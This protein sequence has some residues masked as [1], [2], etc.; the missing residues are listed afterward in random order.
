MLDSTLLES[1][2]TPGQVA[3]KDGVPSLTAPKILDEV[4]VDEVVLT[5]VKDR[6]DEKFL[7]S[8][9]DANI[10][11]NSLSVAEA[12]PSQ[13]FLNDDE[14]MI[15]F[16]GDMDQESDTDDDSDEKDGST[17]L[18]EDSDPTAQKRNLLARL[19]VVEAM[20]QQV[21]KEE[22]LRT[23]R[24]ASFTK[25][26]TNNRVI[27]TSP[28]LAENGVDHKR[29]RR[30]NPK[31]FDAEIDAEFQISGSSLLARASFGEGG[32]GVVNIPDSQP[33][34]NGENTTTAA[35]T[36]ISPPDYLNRIRPP[37]I[38][39]AR[40]ALAQKHRVF[41]LSE[42]STVAV[43]TDSNLDNLSIRELHEA[44]RKAFGRDTS[45][46]DKHWLKRQI[47][48]GLSKQNA[49][50]N[51]KENNRSKSTL[52]DSN[53]KSRAEK[54]SSAEAPL[55][56]F[57]TVG[58]NGKRKSKGTE[59]IFSPHECKKAHRKTLSLSGLSPLNSPN[60]GITGD[61][62]GGTNQEGTLSVVQ[63]SGSLVGEKRIRKPNRRYI[64]DEGDESLGLA[65]NGSRNKSLRASTRSTSSIR[66]TS[67]NGRRSKHGNNGI[68]K[69][70]IDSRAAKLVKIAHS[71]RAARLDIQKT[72][73]KVKFRLPA[74]P[75]QE[76]GEVLNGGDGEQV[77][78]LLP[79]RIDE[80]IGD[81][82]LL[83]SQYQT[84]S[85]SNDEQAV[86]TVPTANGGTRRKHH[87][88]WTLREVLTLVEG[89]ARCGGGKWADIKKLAFSTVSYR[90][91]VDLKD[92][93]RNLLRAS[94]AQL[95]PPK[96]GETR[97]KQ[98]SAA[99][100]SQLLAR[101]RELAALNNQAVSNV[102]AGSS[103]SRSGRVV[104]R[105]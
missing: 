59:A 9:E 15:H 51:G 73:R 86:V 35:V 93:W 96:Q 57:S 22:Q 64:E 95:H 74:A 103:T 3:G 49:T 52:T 100:P 102:S 104:H 16:D 56:T 18:L 58:V 27:S 19:K 88:P 44:Y 48:M 13:N 21:A 53:L 82:E 55:V 54:I 12:D 61:C 89:V 5:T 41:S 63:T 42:S 23:Q 77:S 66:S 24:E 60:P 34:Q 37:M 2:G 7:P 69:K 45:V 81:H 83:N 14:H 30:P 72:I 91:A 8:T 80:T 40:T 36:S 6:A 67:S 39:R 62:S 26:G 47:F 92:K 28:V 78:C 90:T 65:A 10:E 94:R 105:R 32:T 101:V 29:Q 97:K 70:K 38:Q 76:K 99:I 31:Y 79:V 75:G 1:K 68:Q 43:K 50:S 98:F 17:A 33:L 85:E 25:A 87:R 71:A 84:R 20:L 4:F 46:K 11:M